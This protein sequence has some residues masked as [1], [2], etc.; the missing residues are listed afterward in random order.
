M[1]FLAH[2]EAE[3]VTEFGEV[4]DKVRGPSAY[5]GGIYTYI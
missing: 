2:G 4:V 3:I 1:F 5:F